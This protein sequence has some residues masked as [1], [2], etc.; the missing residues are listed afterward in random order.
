MPKL[1]IANRKDLRSLVQLMRE[2]YS[3]DNIPWN[4]QIQPALKLL[5]SNRKY[6]RVWLIFVNE[7]VAG[8]LILTYGFDLEFGGPQAIVTDLFIRPAF[9]RSGFG[10]AAI[11]T[12]A[13]FCRKQ[14]LRTLELQVERHNKK[15]QIF[16][17][18]MGFTAHE[19]LPFSKWIEK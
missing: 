3:Y 6:G 19:R 7:E 17:K 11:E 14:K 4:Q 12:A 2:Y 13:R 18:K 15:A 5:L 10:T 16:Y 8:Y 9:R 1:R